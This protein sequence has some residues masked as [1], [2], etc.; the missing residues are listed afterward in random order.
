MRSWTAAGLIVLASV[1]VAC[2]GPHPVRIGGGSP[3]QTQGSMVAPTSSPGGTRLPV[4]SIDCPPQSAYLMSC[5]QAIVVAA[6]LI[7]VLGQRVHAVARYEFRYH[8][9]RVRLLNVWMQPGGP[10]DQFRPGRCSLGRMMVFVDEVT[11]AVTSTQWHTGPSKRCP[12][13]LR[14]LALP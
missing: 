9:W 6:R 3:G 10:P 5:R 11:G 2:T 13:G 1:G 8:G 14:P 12:R 4:V 7:P